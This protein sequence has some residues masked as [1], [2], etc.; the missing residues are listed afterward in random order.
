M[1]RPLY[2]VSGARHK[3]TAQ[4]T[5]NNPTPKSTLAQTMHTKE[6]LLRHMH[7]YIAPKP[8]K[9]TNSKHSL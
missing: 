2:R 8:T 7:K 6:T 5:S 1:E 9:C 4:Y 3:I